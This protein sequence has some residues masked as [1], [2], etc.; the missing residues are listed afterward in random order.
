[1]NFYLQQVINFFD[2]LKIFPVISTIIILTVFVVIARAA[3]GIAGR[4]IIS[5]CSDGKAELAK[6]LR[7]SVRTPIWAIFLMFGVM[8]VFEWFDLFPQ[9]RSKITVCLGT[10]VLL[11]FATTLNKVVSDFC[12]FWRESK[13]RSVET[14]EQVEKGAKAFLMVVCFFLLLAIWK[15]DLAPLL[16]SAGFAGIV[17]AV[18]A[19]DL[20]SNLF[21]GLSLTLAKP[22]KPGDYIVLESGERG[23]VVWI[24]LRSTII[25]T[26]DDAQISIPNSIMANT[27]IKNESA[28][29][30]RY[31]I[32]IKVGVAYGSDFDQV[33]ETFLEV[34]DANKKISAFP[35]PRVRFRAFG[36][37]A[38]EFELL[39]WAER[40]EDRGVVI[41]Q[42][43][44]TIYK[45]FEEK[46]IK[47]PFPQQDI[48]LHQ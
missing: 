23:K 40:P 32:R 6:K 13:E 30:P 45:N 18:A 28:P 48:Y 9:S 47:I 4:M 16:A 27:R 5:F 22:F 17:V 41:H 44:K 14:I 26:R 34:A 29:I 33:E 1:M 2:N 38:I 3:V 35:E 36:D 25:L 12:N 42:L 43:G 46:K 19:K 39:C 8:F 11:V 15:I 10:L 21:G 24:G 31:R 7:R 20:L 37:S